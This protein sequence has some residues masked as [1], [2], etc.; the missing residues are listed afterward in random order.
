MDCRIPSAVTAHVQCV[1][2][3][4]IG[5]VIKRVEC[6]WPYARCAGTLGGVRAARV[7][8]VPGTCGTDRLPA[9]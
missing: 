4:N 8:V 5:T 2:S 6:V 3:S 9:T 7:W 1:T